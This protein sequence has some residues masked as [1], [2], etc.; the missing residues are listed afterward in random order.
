MSIQ[1][2]RHLLS[3]SN[4]SQKW[5]NLRLIDLRVFSLLLPLCG[6]VIVRLQ[7]N[8]RQQL[9]W[10]PCWF[11]IYAR[12]NLCKERFLCNFAALS[13]VDRADDRGC[14]YLVCPYSLLNWNRELASVLLYIITT[15]SKHLHLLCLVYWCWNSADCSKKRNVCAKC[16]KTT[17]TIIGG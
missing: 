5:M 15:Y 16:C 3:G 6:V 1:S 12:N 9:G 7:K 14:H 2:P 8:S 10:L 11:Q 13:G 17:D 4:Q